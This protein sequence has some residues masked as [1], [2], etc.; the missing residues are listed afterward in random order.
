MYSHSL[1]SKRNFKENYK[2]RI[3]IYVGDIVINFNKIKDNKKYN[4]YS[5]LNKLWIHGLVH[6]FGFKHYKITDYK[7]M[8]VL[9]KK[10]LNHINK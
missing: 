6:L 10:I 7:K 9:E 1:F 8:N 2:K 5:E 3:N 4:F